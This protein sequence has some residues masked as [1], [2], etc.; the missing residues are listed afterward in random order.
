MKIGTLDAMD[1]VQPMRTAQLGCLSGR[2]IEHVTPLGHRTV[3]DIHERSAIGNQQRGNPGHRTSTFLGIRM[4]PHRSGEDRIEPAL[5]AA[6]LQVRQVVLDPVDATARVKTLCMLPQFRRSC[7]ACVGVRRRCLPADGLAA[8]SL[9]SD[10]SQFP[11]P[12]PLQRL[13]YEL[14]ASL[15]VTSEGILCPH[16][17]T[18]R[19][20][21]PEMWV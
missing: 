3:A 15:K 5:V 20:P 12:T 11:G 17:A 18:P 21:L 19:T 7:G 6:R 1:R 8:H 14:A 16:P 2:Y 13:P 4:H 10:H 9:R